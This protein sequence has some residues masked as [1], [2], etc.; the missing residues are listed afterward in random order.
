MREVEPVR[1]PRAVGRGSETEQLAP[2]RGVRVPGER[3][4]GLSRGLRFEHDALHLG[5]VDHAHLALRVYAHALHLERAAQ[6]VGRIDA[7]AGD[8]PFAD[9]ARTHFMRL[10][11]P[12]PFHVEFGMA[13]ARATAALL[14]APEELVLSGQ[15]TAQGY[16]DVLVAFAEER[17]RRPGVELRV[18]RNAVHRQPLRRHAR[19]FPA[20]EIVRPGGHLQSAP[21]DDVRRL[22]AA[23]KRRCNCEYRFFHCHLS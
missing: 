4:V 7:Q 17:C 11:G 15:G 13:L 8:A 19:I 1:V 9:P 14:G 5:R 21:S 12:R 22:Q 23:D 10:P 18:V 16:L 6:A 3:G 2:R 20:R